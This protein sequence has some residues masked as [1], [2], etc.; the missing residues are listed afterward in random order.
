MQ[1][2]SNRQIHRHD[3]ADVTKHPVDAEDCPG[4][5]DVICC[6]VIALPETHNHTITVASPSFFVVVNTVN[7]RR[8][9]GSEWKDKR[10]Q[11]RKLERVRKVEGKE[12]EKQGSGV[13]TGDP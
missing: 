13:A 11:G 9:R 3:V 12:T 7:I 5:G 2:K 1:Q 10:K 8:V 6:E 4:S